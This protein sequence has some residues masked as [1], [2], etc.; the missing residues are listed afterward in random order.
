MASDSAGLKPITTEFPASIS[1]NTL[2]INNTVPSLT[3][4]E[5][6]VTIESTAT[7]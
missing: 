7:F 5:F 2:R 4:Y 3:L 6:Y 1:A